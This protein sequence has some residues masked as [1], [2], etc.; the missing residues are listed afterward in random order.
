MDPTSIMWPFLRSFMVLLL[1]LYLNKSAQYIDLELIED[2]IEININEKG[3][4]KPDE[5][6][7]SSHNVTEV[8]VN[9]W[10][11]QEIDSDVKWG[12]AT[13]RVEFQGA[14]EFQN[15]TVLTTKRFGK[16]LVFDGHLQNTEMDEYIYHESLVHPALLLHN[17]PKTVFIMG[18][19]GGSA[20]REALRHRNIKKVKICDI[21]KD[22]SGLIRKHVRAN[23]KAFN[24]KRL[25]IVYNDAK[26]ELEKSKEKFD[27]IIGDLP[28]PNES[29]LCNNLYTKSFYEHVANQNLKED[30]LFVTQAGPAGILTHKAVFSPIYNTLKQ[31]FTYVI[32]YTTVVPSYGDLY[33]WIMASNKPINLDSEQLNKRI[34]E[35]IKGEL[36]YL[37]GPLITA[38]TALSKTLKKSLMK[39]TRIFTEEH[40]RVGFVRQ[41]G[42]RFEEEARE[43]KVMKE[44][45]SRRCLGRGKD[46]NKT[47]SSVGR[48]GKLI[49]K[50]RN[51]GID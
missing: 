50:K 41:R 15:L 32:A 26:D 42:I 43:P 1:P 35:R 12:L 27:V 48:G 30:G 5:D 25:Q 17:E 40:M 13:N 11:E 29:K 24:D 18:G 19:G 34:G 33:G 49:S 38:S 22:I 36:R 46:E 47:W 3:Q 8:T 45:D 6:E 44:E 16:A 21:D 39:E 37:D 9:H 23:H 20:A 10:F 4:K 2:Y 28:D 51:E 7:P 14:S 31:V